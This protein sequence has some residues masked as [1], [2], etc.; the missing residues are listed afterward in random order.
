MR[1]FA[2]IPVGPDRGNNFV[3]NGMGVFVG[4]EG[5]VSLGVATLIPLLP[6]GKSQPQG[7]WA[8]TR[9]SSV[10]ASTSLSPGLAKSIDNIVIY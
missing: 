6:V 4:T 2:T 9:L 7:R 5:R 1:V 8:K 3:R 10:N